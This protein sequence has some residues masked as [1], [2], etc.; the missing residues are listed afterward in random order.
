MRRYHEKTDRAVIGLLEGLTRRP[1]PEQYREL[2]VRLGHKLAKHLIERLDP[3]ASV[4]V[5]CTNEDADFL[6][7]GLLEELEGAGFSRLTLACFWNERVRVEFGNDQAPIIRAYL[8]P[9]EDVD[10]LVV[11]KSIISSGCTIRTNL[12]E[13]FASKN[14]TH[15]EIISPVLLKGAQQSLA[16]EFAPEVS[17]RFRYFWFAEDDERKE[18]GEVIPGIG[19]SVYELLGLGPEKNRYTPEIVKTR[20]RR[21]LA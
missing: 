9:A 4:L 7:R 15:I 2:M 19:G 20:R 17:E 5:V 13:L 14:P 21:I 12:A 6:T 10:T 16:A 11:V 3:A 1:P 18:D 8:E